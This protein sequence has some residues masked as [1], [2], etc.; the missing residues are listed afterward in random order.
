MTDDIYTGLE[1]RIFDVFN[2][3]PDMGGGLDAVY[4]LGRADA[5]L[6]VAKENRVKL[7][8]IQARTR[9]EREAWDDGFATAITAH[10][11]PNPTEPRRVARDERTVATGNDREALHGV[12]VNV[13]SNVSNFPERA[14]SRLLGQDMGPLRG[15]VV[16]AVLTSDVWRNRTAK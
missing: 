15:M 10:P 13:L 1:G 12:L 5:F 6:E 14:Q 7:P 2:H 4:A 16:D 8:G 3:H 11:V 9:E